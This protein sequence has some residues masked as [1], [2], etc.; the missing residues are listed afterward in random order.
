MGFVLDDCSAVGECG[1]LSMFKVGWA[2][3]DVQVVGYDKQ[4]FDLQYF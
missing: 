3:C 1:V 2:G 4:I